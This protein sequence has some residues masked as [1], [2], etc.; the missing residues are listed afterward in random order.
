VGGYPAICVLRRLALWRRKVAATSFNHR[1]F[2][3]TGAPPF[4]SRFKI[5]EKC[6]LAIPKGDKAQS[7]RG[8]RVGATR[9]PFCV[10]V[11][12]MEMFPLEGQHSCYCKKGF[13]WPA[14][15][16]PTVMRWR[17]AASVLILFSFLIPYGSGFLL[18]AGSHGLSCGRECCQRPKVCCCVKSGKYAGQDVPSWIGSAKCPGGCGQ[19]PTARRTGSASLV[20]TRLKVRRILPLSH[21]RMSPASP[22]DSS[23]H[24][25]AL[26]ERPPPYA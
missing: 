10:R 15:L 26:F 3:A 2:A 17:A 4:L 14:I 1:F 6:R 23:G 22:R 11:C 5:G 18:L 24:T 19:L 20:A 9:F 8:L 21:L 7:L 25:F 12:F 13:R 16:A